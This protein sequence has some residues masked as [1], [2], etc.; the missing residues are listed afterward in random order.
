MPFGVD[1][2][3]FLAGMGQ[4]N[5]EEFGAAVEGP[6]ALHPYLE[7][8]AQDLRVVTGQQVAAALGDLIPAVDREA[9]SG[10][11]GT[12]ARTSGTAEPGYL[13]WLTTTSRSST[14]GL[15]PC[16]DRRRRDLAGRAGPDGALRAWR[17]AHRRASMARPG[18]RTTATVDPGDLDRR[19]PR[20]PISCCHGSP[21]AARP[22]HARR[23]SAR[24]TGGAD[25][26]E[27]G[28]AGRRPSEQGSIA[29]SDRGRPTMAICSNPEWSAPDGHPQLRPPARPGR[30][31][32]EML[33][34]RSGP[35]GLQCRPRHRPARSP[36]A[37]TCISICL[38]GSPFTDF[39]PG[40]ILAA[41]SAS[42]RLRSSSWP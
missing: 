25:L 14:A 33:A 9:L 2:F 17:V 6:S 16:R 36:T 1:G 37:A 8:F 29:W 21:A 41:C 42:A 20:R 7:R 30:P 35:P 39:V 26:A 10:E 23:R 5:I 13:G 15:R 38:A 22:R 31:R 34:S 19:R 27:V 11:Y 18:C 40:L 28:L 4:E 12:F 3:D 24:A 32:P